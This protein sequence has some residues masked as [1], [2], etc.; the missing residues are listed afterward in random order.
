MAKVTDE[1]IA[2]IVAVFETGDKPI[3]SNYETLI[4]AIQEAAQD[5]EHGPAGG[6]GTGAGDASAINNLAYGPDASK[7]ATPAVGMVYVASDTSKQ[8]TCFTVNIWTQI[9]P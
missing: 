4:T 5:H 8:Y 1:A 3:G 9:Y 6:T 2:A 7:T